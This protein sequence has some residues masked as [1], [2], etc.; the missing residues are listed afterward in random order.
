MSDKASLERSSVPLSSYL[1]R[2]KL[3]GALDDL[4]QQTKEEREDLVVVDD[5]VEEAAR[6]LMGLP[7][8]GAGLNGEATPLSTR[9]RLKGNS[10]KRKR[11]RKR[12]RKDLISPP[13]DSDSNTETTGER[14]F[15]HVMTLFDRKVDLARFTSATPLYVMCREWMCNNPEKLSHH[16]HT[17]TAHTL[18][19]GTALPPPVPLEC[20]SNGKVIRLDVPRPFSP[21]GDKGEFHQHLNA[22]GHHCQDIATYKTAHLKRWKDIKTSWRQS[23]AAN[24][25][26]YKDSLR[27]IRA[28][29]QRE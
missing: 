13:E 11:G 24:Q 23:S 14:H 28:M 27:A 20:D 29:Y 22:E 16:P 8:R 21:V 10:P 12:K 15:P 19:T 1:G 4:V 3:K 7:G 6:E 5:D 26:R 9:R 17:S 25:R 2:T 18:P